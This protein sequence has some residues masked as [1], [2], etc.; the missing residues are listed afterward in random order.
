MPQ[1]NITKIKKIDYQTTT[2]NKSEGEA[3]S[4]AIYLVVERPF[5]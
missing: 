2:K 1:K 5:K 4:Y 3:Q